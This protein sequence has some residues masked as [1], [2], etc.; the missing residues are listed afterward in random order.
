MRQKKT[1]L[2]SQIRKNT[3]LQFQKKFA[4]NES[5]PSMK[6]EVDASAN[7]HG[8]QTGDLGATSERRT[9]ANISP[10]LT[11]R[12][13]SPND[14]SSIFLSSILDSKEENQL[15]E[16]L[17]NVVS[18]PHEH[19][20]QGSLDEGSASEASNNS[21]NSLRTD[22]LNEANHSREP[23]SFFGAF[24]AY[25]SG[26]KNFGSNFWPFW[27]VFNS[28][29]NSHPCPLFVDLWSFSNKHD[30]VYNKSILQ[31]PSSTW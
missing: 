11:P 17:F 7:G 24:T 6:M 30:K 22:P 4:I 31:I 23:N 20:Q 10:I 15:L 9:P 3:I 8:L 16:D 12:V 28:F 1:T 21:F 19:P 29:L 26:L 27:T 5:T 25:H 14:L 18:D 2:T 13:G